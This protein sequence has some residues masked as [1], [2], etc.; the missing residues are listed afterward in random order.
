MSFHLNHNSKAELSA[1]KPE[2]EKLHSTTDQLIK[3]NHPKSKEI[4]QIFENITTKWNQLLSESQ[5]Q[6]SVLKEAKDLLVFYD[7]VCNSFS[8]ELV[9]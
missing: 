7:E 4:K 6:S 3:D 2:F 8:K 1:N 5:Y 9:H